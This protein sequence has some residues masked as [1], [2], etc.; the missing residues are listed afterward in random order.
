MHKNNNHAALAYN[1]TIH[2]QLMDICSPLFLRSYIKS[3]RY[4]RLFKDGSYLNLSTNNDWLY[5]RMTKIHNNGLIFQSALCSAV[6]DDYT[7]FI[8]PNDPDADEVTNLFYDFNIWNGLSVYKRDSISVETWSFGATKDHTNLANYYINNMCLI[9]DF[10]K[11]FNTKGL[12]LI[13]VC[14]TKKLAHFKE[15]TILDEEKNEP[16]LFNSQSN[17]PKSSF[18]DKE[19]T[20]TFRELQCISMISRGKTYKEIATF[21]ELSPRTVESYIQ[22]AKNK[23]GVSFKR[24][25]IDYYWQ[26]SNKINLSLDCKSAR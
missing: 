19:V 13:D 9:K 18:N 2:Q 4:F 21:L 1:Q 14:D 3:F 16:I 20:F 23:L 11:D 5:S 15:T 17:Q 22:D 24:N 25:L 26:Y 12:P 7:F 8:W 6:S 10:V